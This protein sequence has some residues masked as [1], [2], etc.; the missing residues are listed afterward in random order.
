METK[1]IL[2]LKTKL[3]ELRSSYSSYANGIRTM[4]KGEKELCKYGQEQ[5]YCLNGLVAGIDNIIKDVA[6]MIKAHNL[7]IQM[8]SL[9]ERKNLDSN[10]TS[11]NSSIRNNN[12]SNVAFYIDAIKVAIRPFCIRTEKQRVVDFLSVINDVERDSIKLKENIESVRQLIDESK[13]TNEDI[14][15]QKATIDT[16]FEEISTQSTDLTAKIS[17]LQAEY[18]NLQSLTVTAE[19]NEDFIAKLLNKANDLSKEFNGFIEKIDKREEILKEQSKKTDNYETKLANY[20]LQHEKVLKDAQDLIDNARQALEYSTAQGLSA[21]FQTQYNEENKVWKRIS[22]LIGASVFALAAIGLGIWIVVSATTGTMQG[23]IYAFLGRFSMI[24][25][26]IYAA[27]FCTQQYTK[28]YNL[29][30]DYAYKAVLAK[31]IIAFSEEL[32]GKDADSYA[33]YIST[34]LKEIHQY[35]LGKSI[36]T[37]NAN[38]E[39]SS[40]IIVKLTELVNSILKGGQ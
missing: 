15:K 8:S 20:T 40:N 36:K 19:K 33:K 6:F 27:I 14:K 18:G 11:L 39:D 37:K 29:K 5:E 30:E 7:F 3:E 35:P 12:H 1:S 10:L 22:W 26:I 21:A 38:I 16:E 9:E 24:P 2:S 17:A 32:R 31:S 25:L 23:N 28:Q 13:I 4:S 34:M